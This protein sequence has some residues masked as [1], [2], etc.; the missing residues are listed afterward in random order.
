MRKADGIPPLVV[1][2]IALTIASLCWWGWGFF[3]GPMFARFYYGVKFSGK[4]LAEYGQFG[5][6]FGGVNALFAAFA[7]AFVAWAGY[8][9]RQQLIRQQEE[10]QSA[11]KSAKKQSFENILF[12]QLRLFREISSEVVFDDERG[13][14]GIRNMAAKCRGIIEENA[15]SFG[16]L[17]LKKN[18]KSRAIAAYDAFIYNDE[19]EPYIGPYFRCLYHVFKTIKMNDHL[20]VDGQVYYANLCRAQLS[21]DALICLSLNG[22]HDR[23]YEFK[24]LIEEFGILK[25]MPSGL[26]SA[27]ALRS[28]RKEAFMSYEERLSRRSSG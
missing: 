14:A 2:G 28:Y 22:I 19:S 16:T 6:M 27:R 18:I 7:A 10:I 12:E 17:V 5:D 8:M 20:E 24:V 15:S 11:I 21:S 13:V 3:L 1:L 26:K 23:G 25:H 4:D 9:Q